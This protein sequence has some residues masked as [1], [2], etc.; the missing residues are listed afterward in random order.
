VDDSSS[1]VTYLPSNAW[2]DTLYNDSSL[3][4]VN[5]QGA[6]ASITFN[7][8][9]V[10]FYGSKNPDYGSYQLEVDNEVV[11]SGSATSS[12]Q[13]VDQLLGGASGL[14]MGQHTAVLTSNG[15]GTIDFDSLIFETQNAT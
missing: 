6:S 7:G 5:V 1:L 12:S 14:T 13:L 10:W 9:G 4:S 2:I 8:T 3:H 15:D 11:A